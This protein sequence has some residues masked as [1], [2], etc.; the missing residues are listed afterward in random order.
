MHSNEWFF[1]G[2]GLFGLLWWVVIIAV[3]VWAIK[4]IGSGG[5]K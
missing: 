2:H 4:T 5:D 1:F 3:V